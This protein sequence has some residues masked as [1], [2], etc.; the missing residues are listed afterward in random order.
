MYSGIAHRRWFLLDAGELEAGVWS[1][2]EL[3]RL[4]VGWP[5]AP[6]G[7]IE[8]AYRS[9]IVDRAFPNPDSYLISG[10]LTSNIPEVW[11]STDGAYRPI[12]GFSTHLAQ[13]E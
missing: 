2:H 13:S 3:G 7:L 4:T 1:S 10:P 5:P 12:N 8:F 9:A 11:H 6:A